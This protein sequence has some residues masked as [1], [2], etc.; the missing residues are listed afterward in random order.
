VEPITKGSFFKLGFADFSKQHGTTVHHGGS[1]MNMFIAR[2]YK[3]CYAE[4][5][6]FHVVIINLNKGFVQLRAATQWAGERCPANYLQVLGLHGQLAL[7][8]SMEQNYR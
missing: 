2:Q 4:Y 6:L 5:N 8:S 7:K 1:W 3:H